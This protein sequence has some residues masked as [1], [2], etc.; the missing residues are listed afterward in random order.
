MKIAPVAAVSNTVA[1]GAPQGGGMVDRLRSM[2]MTTNVTPENI[3]P[4]VQELSNSDHNETRVE[5]EAN[6]QPLSPQFAELAKRR[7]SLQVK[8][9]E[10]ADREKALLSRSQ[11]GSAIEIARLKS[12]P[13]RVLQE[14]GVTYDDLTNA[15]MATQQSPELNDL[16]AEIKA[17]KEGVDKRFVDRET[18]AEQQ[19]LAEMRK[20]A[21][22]MAS[23]GDD[24]E[25]VR[26]TR[27]IPDVMRLIEQTYRETGEVLDTGEALKL[28]EE[29]L[30]TEAQKL[31]GL[32][33]VQSQLNPTPQ[34]SIQPQRQGMRT[35][36]NKDTASVPLSAKQR[37][38]AA[39]YG[40]LKK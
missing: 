30:F 35:L 38:L 5:Q 37:A 10:L 22:L 2:K 34:P 7:R 13:L 26:E 17:L 8:E 18:Q 31:A 19:V 40:T 11:D 27:S 1:E 16:R 25:L 28:V 3:P 21:T 36:T 15:I 9:R 29:Y 23:Q 20:E 24:F 32:K 4:P 39:F 33:K 12:E 14:A 6:V